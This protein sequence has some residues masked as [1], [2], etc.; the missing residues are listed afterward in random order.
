MLN[1]TNNVS[2]SGKVTVTKFKNPMN[3][4]RTTLNTS[5]TDDRL[6]KLTANSIIKNGEKHKPIENRFAAPFA[7]LIEMIT[8]KKINLGEQRKFMSNMDNQII[9]QDKYPKTDGESIIIDLDER[10]D[11]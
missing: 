11:I 3:Y 10:L 6:I 7:R 5:L 8:G 2:F 4:T 1:T 9:F